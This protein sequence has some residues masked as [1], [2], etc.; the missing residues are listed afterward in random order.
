MVSSTPKRVLVASMLSAGL[1]AACT[2]STTSGRSPTTTRPARAVALLARGLEA[3]KAAVPWSQVGP[4]WMLAD[5]TPTAG[6]GAGGAPPGGVQPDDLYLV[7]PLGGR[8]LLASP[9]PGSLLDWSGDGKRALFAQYSS[10]QNQQTSL[11][12]LDLRTGSSHT[13]I[14]GAWSTATYTK[15]EGLAVLLS[16]AG[17]LERVGLTGML[18]QTYPSSFP[19]VG[20]AGPALSSPD[21]TQLVIGA[22][23]GLALVAN[24]AATIRELPVP[25]VSQGCEPLR[26]WSPGLVLA[27]CSLTQSTLWLVPTSGA[28]PSALTNTPVLPDLGDEDAWQ[29]GGGTYVQDAGACGY[30]YLAKLNP[31]GTTT[32]VAVPAVDAGDSVVVVGTYDNR[33]ALR[34]T[35]ACGTGVS[36]VWFDPEANTTTVLLGPSVNGGGVSDAILYPEPGY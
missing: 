5:W 31:N 29:V 9:S 12:E 6:F 17:P 19:G 28:A 21:G 27:S 8:Y 2:S 24:D 18:Q 1:L 32:P 36:L 34:A 4:G 22:T 15:P 3:T 26:W 20:T 25:S 23:N 33:L 7:N 30:Q 14:T 11:V 13:I 35:V 16:G 10:G